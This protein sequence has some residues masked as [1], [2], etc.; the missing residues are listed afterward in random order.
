MVF[1]REASSLFVSSVAP[2]AM[3]VSQEDSSVVDRVRGKTVVV[4]LGDGRLFCQNQNRRI[5]FGHK[6]ER[7]EAKKI[8]EYDEKQTL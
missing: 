1:A 5:F 3:A 6:R 7:E 4:V 8:G 2:W